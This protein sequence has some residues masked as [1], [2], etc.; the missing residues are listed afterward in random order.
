MKKHHVVIVGGGFAGLYAA[1]RLGNAAVKVTMIDKRNF[2]LFQPLLYQV[3]TGGLSPGDISS[4]LRTV[5]NKYENTSVLQAEMTDINPK[6][7][8]IVLKDGALA[9]DSLVIATGAHFNYFCNEHWAEAAPGLK[10]IEDALEIRR[11]ILLAFEAAERATDPEKQQQLLNFV[12]I[13]GGA[14]GVEL[15]GALAELT[16]HTMRHDFRNINPAKSK[17]YLIEGAERL[18]GTYQDSLS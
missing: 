3:A 7:N 11:R 16:Y 5:L 1:Q 12:I 8:T 9:Y 15:A 4:P 17:I 6:E 18:L 2:H 14:T 13:G 10:T